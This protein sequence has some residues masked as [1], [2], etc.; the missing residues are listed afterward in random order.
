M[1]VFGDKNEWAGIFVGMPRA[2]ACLTLIVEVT[3]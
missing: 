1:L 3:F 2:A